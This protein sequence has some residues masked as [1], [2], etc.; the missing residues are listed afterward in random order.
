MR[1]T[2]LALSLPHVPGHHDKGGE[3]AH[4]QDDTGIESQFRFPRVNF[5]RD[6]LAVQLEINQMVLENLGP[7]LIVVVRCQDMGRVAAQFSEVNLAIEVLR[8]RRGGVEVIAYRPSEDTVVER[9][10]RGVVFRVARKPLH[11]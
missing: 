7:P 5:N 4:L 1:L 3:N 10:V 11:C 6:L 9:R 2:P 8:L